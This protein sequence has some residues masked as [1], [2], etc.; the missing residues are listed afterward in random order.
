M[1]QHRHSRCSALNKENSP[2]KISHFLLT[3]EQLHP[4]TPT[5][6]LISVRATHSLNVEPAILT[7]VCHLIS[8]P[9]LAPCH[10]QGC[11]V[12]SALQLHESSPL[13]GTPLEILNETFF[14]F[15]IKELSAHGP[16]APCTPGVREEGRGSS[17]H[18]VS[19]YLLSFCQG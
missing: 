5:H 8:P 9:P 10:R 7:R 1:T 14:F 11:Q 18:L 4:L 15:F 13:P 17:F 12:D 3:Q 16:D 6:I 19:C 2:L